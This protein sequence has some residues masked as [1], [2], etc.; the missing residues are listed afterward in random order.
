Q[1]MKTRATISQTRAMQ[2]AGGLDVNTGT[3]VAVRSSE[4]ELGQFDQA[5]I[6]NNAARRAYGQEVMG[7]QETAKANLYG[8]AA[9][10]SETAGMFGAF[11]SILG[12]GGSFASKWQQGSSLGMPLMSS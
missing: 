1:G 6:R 10:T 5:V 12:A 11:T 7:F 8:M 3:N 4:L 9:S 2:G